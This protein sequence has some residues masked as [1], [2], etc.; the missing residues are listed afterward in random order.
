MKRLLLLALLGL[1]GCDVYERPN[2]PVPEWF[3]ATTLDGEVIDRAA[4]E[5]KPWIIN[6]WI[7]G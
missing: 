1:V 4:L 6:I 2:R 7:P 5:G 3:R